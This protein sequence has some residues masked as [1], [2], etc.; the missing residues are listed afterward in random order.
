MVKYLKQ[1][2]SQNVSD[3]HARTVQI[4]VCWVLTLNN[5]LCGHEVSE[6]GT[7]QLF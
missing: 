6:P 4:A 7:A 2:V 3:F 5:F 1:E